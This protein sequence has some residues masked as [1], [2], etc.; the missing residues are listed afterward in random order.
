MA[1]AGYHVSS[2]SEIGPAVMHLKKSG[3]CIPLSLALQRQRLADLFEF[4]DSLVYRA[5]SR[6]ARATK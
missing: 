5:S 6:T 3:W 1:E 4:K 2:L